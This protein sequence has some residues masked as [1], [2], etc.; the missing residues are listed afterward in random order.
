[1]MWEKVCWD[2]NISCYSQ[3]SAL[4][5]RTTNRVSSE[6]GEVQYEEISS[7]GVVREGL[8][9]TF[10]DGSCEPGETYRY[11]IDISDES[12]RR[13]FFET[14]PISTPVLPI[15]LYQNY[16]NPFNPSTT[17]KYYLPE[18]EHVDL[19]IYDIAGRIVATLVSKQQVEGLYVIEWN[20]LDKLGN[21]VSSGIYFYK[22]IAGKETISRKMV[23]LR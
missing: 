21:S 17:I 8:H 7:A 15:A 6:T 1:M 14:D 10:K 16:P 13:I 23:L 12:G 9:F 2:G 5:S 11:R 4:G 3:V 20:G 18:T 22:L 19:I